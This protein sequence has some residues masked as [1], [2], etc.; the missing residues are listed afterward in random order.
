MA[1]IPCSA[2]T[3]KMLLLHHLFIHSVAT[4]TWAM[5]R[6]EMEITKPREPVYL[7]NC[8]ENSSSS[9]ATPWLRD[10][11][12]KVNTA[13]RCYSWTLLLMNSL[14][15]EKAVLIWG[16]R[17]ARL[18]LTVKKFVKQPPRPKSRLSRFQ[19]KY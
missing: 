18:F 4:R 10:C 14:V 11:P 13:L 7:F 5:F 9:I 1:G 2:P 16:M 12:A 6:D 19:T 8:L 17:W 3:I 15:L